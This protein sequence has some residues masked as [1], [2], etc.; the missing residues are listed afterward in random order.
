MT[1][2]GSFKALSLC[3]R[4]RSTDTGIPNAVRVRRLLEL[5]P[6]LPFE[7]PRTALPLSRRPRTSPRAPFLP[8]NPRLSTAPAPGR[9][10]LCHRDPALLPALATHRDTHSPSNIPNLL[11]LS[12]SLSHPSPSYAPPSHF[13]ARIGKRAI[14]PPVPHPAHPTVLSD[15][16]PPSQARLHDWVRS[17]RA[18]RG[19]HPAPRIAK[20]GG[21]L[22]RLRG[23]ARLGRRSTP[24]HTDAPCRCVPAR[25]VA[26]R[27]YTAADPHP[28][29]TPPE[30]SL[31]PRA[32]AV[33]LPTR[34]THSQ[35]TAASAPTLRPAAVADS[36][37]HR[38]VR[39][40]APSEAGRPPVCAG[41]RTPAT[42]DGLSGGPARRPISSRRAPAAKT[43]AHPPSH[44]G[45][46]A[47]PP[48]DEP[49]SAWCRP[50][51][52]ALAPRASGRPDSPH[53]R[54]APA[55]HRA[56]GAG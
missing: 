52:C 54:A 25:R 43:P 55:R 56:P 46:D 4:F 18:P 48:R 47:A 9:S 40:H 38:A 26:V 53:L 20:L 37:T 28:S 17:L 30:R 6:L 21:V 8:L 50:P 23:S 13:S 14:R 24:L 31:P 3:S 33:P 10:V 7:C 5:P 22:S 27:G 49:P 12:L 19:P 32:V 1:L 42:S 15:V 39:A 35:P 2:R 44:R 29:R 45:R 41:A 34:C 16:R 51:A 36:R 11:P